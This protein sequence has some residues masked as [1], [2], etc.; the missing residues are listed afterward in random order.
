MR[1]VLVLFLACLPSVTMAAEWVVPAKPGALKRALHE[2]AAGDVLRLAPGRHQGPVAVDRSLTLEGAGTAHVDAGGIGSVI[3]VAAPDVVV[4]GLVLSGSGSSHET[5]DA[6]VKLG[7]KA[8]RSLVENNRLIGNL[9][10]VDIHGALDARVAGNI[11]IGRS[12]F[13]IND[14]GNGVYVWNA[15]GAIVEDNDI[16]MGRDGIFSNTSKHNV[17]RNNRFRNLRFA[18]HYMYTN[19]SEVSGNVSVGNDLGFAI[20]YSSRIRVVA[21]RSEGD[22]RHGLL[23]NYANNSFIRDNI[24]TGGAE[25]CVFIYN[26]N[27]NEISGN[28]FEDCGIGIHFTAGSERN[29][30]AENAFIGNRKQVKYVGTRLVEWSHN[31]RG[32]F[33]SDNLGVDLNGD[34]I[35]DSP[36]RPNDVVDQ[37]VWRHPAAKML[38]SSPA[39]QVLRWAQSAFPGLYPG[40]VRDSAPLMAPPTRSTG[41]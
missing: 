27:K 10:G 35:G 39:F 34:G 30:I 40:G 33:W 19:D 26:A 31:G 4:R 6:G 32:N 13:R 5:I 38:L 21:N 12:D 17:F 18:V 8:V 29:T 1:G 14:R 23:L 15:P 16:S 36:Y 28:R 37:I 25:K 9:Y 20:M 24:V 22:R 11:I 7:K 2:A 3:T 41:G